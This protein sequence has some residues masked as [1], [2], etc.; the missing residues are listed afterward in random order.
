MDQF[1]SFIHSERENDW[2]LFHALTKVLFASAA[3]FANQG[4]DVVVDSVFER[5]QCIEASLY[6]LKNVH[7]SFVGLNCPIDILER[8]ERAR[9]NRPIGWARNQSGRIHDDCIY[10]LLLDTS[11]LSVEECAARILE[12]FGASEWPAQARMADRAGMG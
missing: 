1:Y 10:D 9:Q 7:T 12:L 5:P 4:F 3:A 6:A 11:E 2:S 8:R